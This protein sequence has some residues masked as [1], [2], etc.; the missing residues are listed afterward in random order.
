MERGKGLSAPMNKDSVLI[1]RND[2]PLDVN[3]V[4]EPLKTDS[5]PH[6]RSPE[7]RLAKMRGQGDSDAARVA[8]ESLCVPRR[9]QRKC[10]SVEPART[11]FRDCRK[12]GQEFSCAIDVG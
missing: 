1:F 6:I 4:A 5:L 7:A 9:L 11:I 8:I 3:R 2:A 10:P 12:E